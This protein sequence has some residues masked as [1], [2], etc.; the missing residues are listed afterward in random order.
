MSLTHERRLKLHLEAEEFR[1]GGVKRT[2]TSWKRRE[3]SPD[4]RLP[5]NAKKL[6]GGLVSLGHSIPDIALEFGFDRHTTTR[7]WLA[8]QR[9][10]EETQVQV[11]REAAARRLVAKN[12]NG[13]YGRTRET[14]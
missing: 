8:F 1:T 4:C 9:F 7:L 12:R 14:S 3:L 6:V 13:K 2:L 10:P 5:M 11:F